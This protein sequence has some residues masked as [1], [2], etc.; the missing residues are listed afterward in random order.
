MAVT[1]INKRTKPAASSKIP[2]QYPSDFDFNARRCFKVFVIGNICADAV[3]QMHEFEIEDIAG[4]HKK[5]KK[6]S[7]NATCNSIT[8]C[9]CTVI[10]G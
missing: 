2:V 7:K 5:K 6:I 3:S 10:T 9:K 1:P 8:V 4:N